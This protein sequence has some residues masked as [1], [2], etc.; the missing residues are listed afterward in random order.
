MRTQLSDEVRYHLPLGS[1]RIFMNE[2]IGKDILL[3]YENEIRCIV[4]GKKTHKSF[5]QGY[6]YNCFSVSPE[7][8]ECILHPERCLAHEGKGRDIEWETKHHLQEHFVYLALSSEIKV[9]VTRS[10]QVPT[11]WIDQ[12]ASSVIRFAKT[13]YRQLAGLIE[14]E[15]KKY[16]TDKTSW[17]KMLRGDKGEGAGDKE[18]LVTQ[19]KRTKEL[20]PVEF[21]PY[22]SDDDSITTINYPVIKYPE[23]VRSIDFEKQ[24][25]LS[26]KL[27]GIKGQYLIFEND[28]VLNVRKHS[29]YLVSIEY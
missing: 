10:T 9:G 20:L 3:K 1:E 18:E 7:T 17:Q 16:F 14:V 21:H 29:G 23:K 19:K 2:L 4:C 8:S 27:C 5:A 24:N 11:R 26:G 28:E 22:Y 15:M 25:S 6:C 12:G 13:P